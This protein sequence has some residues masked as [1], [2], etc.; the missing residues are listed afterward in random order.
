MGQHRDGRGRFRGPPV[1][2]RCTCRCRGRGQR[3]PRAQALV[4]FSLG[5]IVFPV[6]VI[7]IR[8]GEDLLLLPGRRADGE[9]GDG[10]HAHRRGRRCR[11]PDWDRC[12]CRRRAVRRDDAL[13]SG[14]SE[15]VTGWVAVLFPALFVATSVIVY[16]PALLLRVLGR[17]L[18]GR[19]ARP[20][21]VVPRPHE[22]AVGVM[23][24]VGVGV[25]VGV[26]RVGVGEALTVAAVIICAVVVDPRVTDCPPKN[27][28]IIGVSRENCPVT[29]TATVSPSAGVVG[30]QVAVE[31]V[32]AMSVGATETNE[33]RDSLTARQTTLLVDALHGSLA[34]YEMGPN[35]ASRAACSAA[36]CA[37]FWI[38]ICEQKRRLKSRA[39]ANSRSMI[40]R[41][42]RVRPGPDPGGGFGRGDRWTVE[43]GD[44]LAVANARTRTGPEGEG[45]VWVPGDL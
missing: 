41:S 15:T 4:E 10:R 26:A 24:V 5:V 16:E 45:I 17:V 27:A 22:I 36:C 20:I 43:G 3:H 35:A 44:R 31:H 33:P 29:R 37:A 34:W 11:R 8:H 32:A 39:P 19:H 21:T 25:G 30:G 9:L 13:R 38:V 28:P 2:R 42:G 40:G 6:L 18:A 12:W 23:F 1:T 14:W 7:G